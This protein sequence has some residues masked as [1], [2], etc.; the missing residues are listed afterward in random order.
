MAKG[1]K[2]AEIATK[3]LKDITL[4]LGGKTQLKT[5]TN[6]ILEAELFEEGQEVFLLSGDERVPVP[7]GDYEM[8]DGSVVS[9]QE[10]GIIGKPKTMEPEK[11]EIETKAE[12]VETKVETEKVEFSED[13]NEAIKAIFKACFEEFKAELKA[14]EKEEEK[15][16]EKVEAAAVEVKLEP[17]KI[18]KHSPEV[19]V[20]QSRV[21]TMPLSSLKG[22]A[23][24]NK[25][26][27]DTVWNNN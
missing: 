13:Q 21:T 3:A 8:E 20:E 25:M 9:V 4:F 14:P 15:E 5:N 24:I 17:I 11:K 18:L 6:A 23:R 12:T 2:V 1:N 27:S 22:Q 26:L 7:I 19:E 16:P 10:L